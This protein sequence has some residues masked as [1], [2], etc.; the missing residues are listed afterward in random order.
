MP[1]VR[2]VH[3]LALTAGDADRAELTIRS[4]AQHSPGEVLAVGVGACGSITGVDEFVTF[5]ELARRTGR[6]PNLAAATLTSAELVAHAAALAAHHVVETRP[7]A[8]AV[9]IAPGVLVLDELTRLTDG[10]ARDVTVV[11]RA[12]LEQDTGR[13]ANRF[14]TLLYAVHSTRAAR[15][16]VEATA[17]WSRNSGALDLVATHLCSSIL[18]GPSSLVALDRT[19]SAHVFALDSRRLTIDGERVLA[20]DLTTLD[21]AVPWILNPRRTTPPTL[22]L[23]EHAALRRTIDLWLAEAAESP[24]ISLSATAPTYDDA[25]LRGELRRHATD[26]SSLPDLADPADV[27]RWASEVLPA[28]H[29]QPVAR[30]LAGVRAGRADLQEVFRHVPGRD[31]E[32]LA[33]WALENGA[34]EGFDASL[35]ESA[36]KATLA[37][38]STPRRQA[39]HR[40]DGVNLVGF[41]SGEFGLGVSARLM[42][43][44]LHEAG[45]STS[46]FDVSDVLLHRRTASFRNGGRRRHNTSLICVNSSDVPYALDRVADVAEG[47]HKIGM[48][49]WELEELPESQRAGVDLVDEVWVA[50]DFMRD[51][52]QAAAPDLPVHTVTPPLPQRPAGPAPVLPPR[53][54]IAPGQPYFLFTFDYLS[55]A[56][57]KNPL[58]LVDAFLR[59]WPSADPGS[60]LLVIKTINGDLAPLQSEHLR[61]V[62]ADHDHIRIVDEYLPDEER[63]VLVAHCSAFVSLHRAEGLGLTIAE[64]MAWSKPVIITAYGGPLQFANTTNAFLVPW[65]PG[66]IERTEGPY[67]AGLRWADPDLDVAARLMR[68]VVE[69]PDLAAALGSRAAQ[70]IREK[71]SVRA[72]SGRVKDLLEESF[73]TR[74]D[75]RT[76]DQGHRQASRRRRGIFSR[77]DRSGL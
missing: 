47:T 20:I 38:D 69:S 25:A 63:H 48:W 13:A 73:A 71:H 59:A 3:V 26:P 68:Q 40:P 72:A 57:R 70:D 21:R 15:A 60:P 12:A 37:A 54:G 6:D 16:L 74:R 61:W 2:L 33:R 41:L 39:A 17:E 76:R 8:V 46:V 14:S 24:R 45:I 65:S 28:G 51:A 77:R 4:I 53:F 67:L 1:S 19:S 29:E 55:S 10:E 52:V 42:D 7:G 49:Y 35:I 64:A 5:D 62:A 27:T 36:A 32:G 18:T 11:T 75:D 30:Y 44:A 50:T 34:A 58:G 22:R 9:V 56:A 43:D 31:S 23:S 66:R